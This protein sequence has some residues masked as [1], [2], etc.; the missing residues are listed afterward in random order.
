MNMIAPSVGRERP[1]Q[2][3]LGLPLSTDVGLAR[4]SSVDPMKPVSNSSVGTCVTSGHDVR[5]VGSKS[6]V[7]SIE[8]KIAHMEPIGESLPRKAHRKKVSL[9]DV[10]AQI[11]AAGNEKLETR[12][13][14]MR[15]WILL[16]NGMSVLNGL[17]DLKDTTLPR[18]GISSREELAAQ[19]ACAL[20]LR[21]REHQNGTL[22]AMA[23]QL[24]DKDSRQLALAEMI[25]LGSTVEPERLTDE[26]LKQYTIDSEASRLVDF[27]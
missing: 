11:Q 5:F 17:D 13:K 21:V 1:A 15:P 24:N 16:D 3:T 6:S 22:V 9:G 12:I 23:R 7:G 10:A 14:G 25:Y 4:M 8:N 20:E 18:I 27:V 19:L 26:E 2:H